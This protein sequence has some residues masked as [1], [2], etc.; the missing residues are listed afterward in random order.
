[1][2]YRDDPPAVCCLVDHMALYRLVGSPEVMAGQMD[3]L[4]EVSA[5]PNVTLQVLP[6]IAH[7]AGASGFMVTDSAAY[8]EHVIGGYTYTE[9]ETVTRL[10]RLFDTIRAE[11]YRAS[12]SAAIIR[13]AGEIWT[14]EQA[15]T[16]TRTAVSASRS[17]RP[18]A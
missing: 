18:K 2:L 4:L 6:A 12:E 16:Q 15:P 11:S 8:A 9:H 5:M 13:K 14:G 10:A 7:P 1:V 3:H 17:R